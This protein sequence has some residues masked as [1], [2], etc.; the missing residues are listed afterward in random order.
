MNDI[1]NG[2]GM[3]QISDSN[4]PVDPGTATSIPAQTAHRFHSFADDLQLLVFSSTTEPL[5]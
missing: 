5:S 1:L 3:I 4:Y 2:S